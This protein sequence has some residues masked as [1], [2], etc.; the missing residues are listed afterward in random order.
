[1]AETRRP[2]LCRM[3]YHRWLGSTRPDNSSYRFCE[4]CGR[5]TSDSK[6][7]KIGGTIRREDLPVDPRNQR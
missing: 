1:M 7:M 2:L 6:S 3:G 5:E 4:R